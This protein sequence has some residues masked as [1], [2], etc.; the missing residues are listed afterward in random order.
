MIVDPE[1]K[2]MLGAVP[3][4]TV[5]VVNGPEGE[6]PDWHA[7]DWRAIED[8]V[9]RLRQRIF[10]ASQAGGLKKGRDL[11]KVVL[12]SRAN[13]LGSGRRGGGGEH[14]GEET[15]GAGRGDA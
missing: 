8:D 2:D 12:R 7:V 9:R 3:T 13:A 1:P 4:G 6:F 10:A 11:Q 15:G 5:G 14:R